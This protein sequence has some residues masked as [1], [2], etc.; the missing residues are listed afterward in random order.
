M[1]CLEEQGGCLV[2]PGVDVMLGLRELQGDSGVSDLAPDVLE[3]ANINPT[4]R[5]AT[6]YLN[7]FNNVIMLL[8]FIATMP[9]FVDEVLQWQPVDYASYFATSHFRHRDLAIAAYTAAEPSILAR[10]AHVVGELD[11]A[12]L[13]AQALLSAHAPDDPAML[14][15][16]EALVQDR[17]RPLISEASGVINGTAIVAQETI[18]PHGANSQHSIDELFV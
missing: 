7:H 9:D 18:E 13:A 16:V 8:E 4:T 6:D 15:R 17:M 10:F 3:A 11:G 14:A 1:A 12:V 2:E 5:L